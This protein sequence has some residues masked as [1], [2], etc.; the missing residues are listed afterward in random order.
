MEKIDENTTIGG[1]ASKFAEMVINQAAKNFVAHS[2]LPDNLIKGEVFNIN[3]SPEIVIVIKA[4]INGQEF[5]ARDSISVDL[6]PKEGDAI[7]DIG[8][9]NNSVFLNKGA[10]EELWRQIK[11]QILKAAKI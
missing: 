3:N 11:H 4:K 5:E 8:S 7:I 6:E 1:L 10:M 9:N 2:P